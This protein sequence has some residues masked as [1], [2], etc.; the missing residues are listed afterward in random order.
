MQRRILPLILALLLTLVPAARAFA[1]ETRLIEIRVAGGSLFAALELR[2]LFPAKFQAILQDGAAIH[3]RLQL[4]LWED[5]P[6]WDK[7]ATPAVISVFRMVLDPQTRAVRVA[8]QYGEVS[9]QPAW[10][11]PLSLRIDLGRPESVSD[12]A[13]YYVRVLATLGTIAEKE[14][15]AA[16]NVVFGDD[17]SSVSIAAMGKMLF[18]AVLTVNEY[19]QSVSTDTR[20]REMTGRELKGGVRL[21]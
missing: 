3:L 16:S 2:E 8:D 12:G 11:E 20:S 6:V 19:L 21:Q 18:R 17:D 9:R 14:S 5:R 1:L 7:L 13:R 10:Q 15:A 4:E